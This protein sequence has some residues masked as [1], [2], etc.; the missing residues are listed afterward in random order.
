MNIT[1]HNYEEY[2]ILYLDNELSSDERRE[3]EIFVQENPDLKNEQ[4]IAVA[5]LS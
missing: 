5:G 1:R 3:V 2:F 4:L